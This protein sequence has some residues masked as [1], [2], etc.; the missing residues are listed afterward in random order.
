MENKC[1]TAE[2]GLEY[3]LFSLILVW[4]SAHCTVLSLKFYI[5]ITCMYFFKISVCGTHFMKEIPL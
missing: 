2:S 3:I 5:T 1:V 4:F